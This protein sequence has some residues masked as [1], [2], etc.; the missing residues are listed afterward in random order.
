MGGARGV[1]EGVIE[2]LESGCGIVD[3]A[4]AARACEGV[5]GYAQH[6][7][8][9]AGGT[10][11]ADQVAALLLASVRLML[12][13]QHARFEDISAA[14]RRTTFKLVDVPSTNSTTDSPPRAR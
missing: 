7:I 9:E 8:V 14:L 11:G 13:V 10:G 2:Q 3:R 4:D 12:G 1:A 6:V 5:A